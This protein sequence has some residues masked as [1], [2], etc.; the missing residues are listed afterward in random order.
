MDTLTEIPRHQLLLPVLDGRMFHSITALI[1]TLSRESAWTLPLSSKWRKPIRSP[2]RAAAWN[3]TSLSD[4]FCKWWMHTKK[5]AIDT[6]GWT[7][8]NRG[9]TRTHLLTLKDILVVGESARRRPHQYVAC[10]S[11]LISLWNWES[12]MYIPSLRNLRE[13]SGFPFR[14][15]TPSVKCFPNVPHTR[16]QS[17]FSLSFTLHCE[18]Q[19]NKTRSGLE[20]MCNNYYM[21]KV[22][23]HDWKKRDRNRKLKFQYAL[24]VVDCARFLFRVRLI[25]KQ[26]MIWQECKNPA[27][28][29]EVFLKYWKPI[30]RYV[31]Y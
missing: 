30:N 16:T 31:L 8:I 3:R 10:G 14:L 13:R 20:R 2:S 15:T 24:L 7:L 29:S 1:F 4:S 19:T 21:H 18:R 9:R 23:L 28:K 17:M 11:E 5:K 6:L 22:F 25:T 12:R 27:D 26:N